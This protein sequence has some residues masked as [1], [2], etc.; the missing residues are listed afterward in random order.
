[1][2]ITTKSVLLS[3]LLFPG[4]GHLFLK[5]YVSAALL[6][7]ASGLALYA[8]ISTAMEKA[9]QLVEQIQRGEVQPDI[10]TITE[11]VLQ[12]TSATEAQ[13]IDTVTTALIVCWIVGVIDAWRVAR[14]RQRKLFASQKKSSLTAES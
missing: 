2:K 6:T 11:M 14:S 5:R 1:M 3:A 9:Q 13:F 10:A 12:Q 8:L 7:S 4:A